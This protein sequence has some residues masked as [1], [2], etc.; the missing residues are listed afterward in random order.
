MARR[1][2]SRLPSAPTEHKVAKVRALK[3]VGASSEEKRKSRQVVASAKHLA[4]MVRPM[5]RVE[6]TGWLVRPREV[7]LRQE[8]PSKERRRQ[9]GHLG[10]DGQDL[11]Y[12]HE[13]KLGRIPSTKASGKKSCQ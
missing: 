3:E 9:R 6:G 10:G 12:D 4:T 11:K 7:R 13:G 5:G 2:A 8:R 1:G